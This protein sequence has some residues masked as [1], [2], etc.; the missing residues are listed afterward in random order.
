MTRDER[1]RITVRQKFI[2]LLAVVLAVLLYFAPKLPSEKKSAEVSE[3]NSDFI[4]SFEEAK[5]N[6]SSE[7][8]II[9]DKTESSLKKAEEEKTETAWIAS[10]GDFLK[11]ARLIQGDKKTIL[12]KGAIESYEKALALNSENLSAKTNLGTAIVESSSL[13][14]TQPMKGIS[15]LRE[16]IRK[17]SNNI[18]ANLQLGLFSVT[19][20]Q[21]DKAIERFKRILR[22]DSTRI[23]MYVYLGDT[24]MQMGEKQKAIT[25]YENYKTR[26][27]DTL[28]IKDIDQ[29]IKKLK[30]Q[31]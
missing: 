28:I 17:D 31:Q 4:S 5:K 7:Q 22:I 19:S 9:F 1:S 13:L 15:L 18:D 16:V 10:A 20:Q 30:Q 23:D 21:F 12:Y 26:V 27:K 24:Y 3:A 14:G 8:K 25:S 29:Y 6:I 2:I 11:G